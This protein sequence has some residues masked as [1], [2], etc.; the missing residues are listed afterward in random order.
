LIAK[1]ENSPAPPLV[2]LRQLRSSAVAKAVPSAWLPVRTSCSFGVS[3]RPGFA[4]V[5]KQAIAAGF[6]AGTCAWAAGA[7]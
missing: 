7:E 4:L 5:T 2:R 1:Q 6:G 3:P